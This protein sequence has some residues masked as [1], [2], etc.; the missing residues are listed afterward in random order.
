MYRRIR[1]DMGDKK[2]IYRPGDMVTAFTGQAGMV[3]SEK[4]L[5]TARKTLRE[6][7]KPGCYF[8][9]GCCTRPDYV[10]Q[11]PVVFEDGTYDVMR[12]MNIRKARDAKEGTR[13]RILNILE[14]RS[15][16]AAGPG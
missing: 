15:T 2:R 3:L 8:A 7:R 14:G 16:K 11:V 1:G 9:P 6:G 4:D 12:T 10:L 13:A 5:Q